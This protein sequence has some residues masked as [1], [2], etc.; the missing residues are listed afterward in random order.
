M[1][2][3]ELSTEQT[4]IFPPTTQSD[5]KQA[6][7]A[8]LGTDDFSMWWSSHAAHIMLRILTVV[9]WSVT[10]KIDPTFFSVSVD[11]SNGSFWVTSKNR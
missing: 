8:L 1:F 10:K 4:A 7:K 2:N 5:P 6:G 3:F 9:W 11:S